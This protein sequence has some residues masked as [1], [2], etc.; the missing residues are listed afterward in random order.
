MKLL[1]TISMTLLS[2]GL[3]IGCS[4]SQEADS[5]TVAQATDIDLA[6]SEWGYNGQDLPFIQF[7]SDGKVSG[8]GGCNQFSGTYSTDG[9]NITFSPLI[10]TRKACVD[11]SGETAFFQILDKTQKYS[12]QHLVLVLKAADGQ[13]IVQLQRRDFD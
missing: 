10:A 6:G 8:N 4:Q 12:A 13:E 7:G 2:V 5:D 11:M 3:V 1:K 9:E